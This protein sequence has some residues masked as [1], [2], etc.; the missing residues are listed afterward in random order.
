MHEFDMDLM[1]WVK[2]LK[3]VEFC[4]EKNAIGAGGF[5]T[6]YKASSKHPFC[7]EF[8]GYQALLACCLKCI[9]DPGQTAEEHNKK[10][11]RTHLLARKISLQ[12]E[13]EVKKC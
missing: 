4:E 5:R 1:S 8:L 13:Q 12:L 9:E 7:A 11:V 10:V 3:T 6:A 2:V